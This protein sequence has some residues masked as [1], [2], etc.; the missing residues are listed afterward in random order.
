VDEI[1]P[2]QDHVE[3]PFSELNN[4]PFLIA[5]TLGT[6]IAFILAMAA[7]GVPVKTLTHQPSAA[8]AGA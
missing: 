5:T 1:F 6:V 4:L 7:A 3:N 2:V 8:N